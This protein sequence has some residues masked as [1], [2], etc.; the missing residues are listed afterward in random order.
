MQ[1]IITPPQET[2]NLLTNNDIPRSSFGIPGNDAANID[3]AG[4]YRVVSTTSSTPSSGVTGSIIVTRLTDGS[5]QYLFMDAADNSISTAT[6][7]SHPGSHP[8]RHHG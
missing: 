1:D 6:A 7:G 2:Y 3:H 4:F 5:L 8:G